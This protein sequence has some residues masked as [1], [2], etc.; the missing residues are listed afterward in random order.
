MQCHLNLNKIKYILSWK[1]YFGCLS[2]NAECVHILPY[3]AGSVGSSVGFG[4]ERGHVNESSKCMKA[5][6]N[7][8]YV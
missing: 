2:C 4:S 8:Y 3:N 6:V 1:G 7:G 5:I